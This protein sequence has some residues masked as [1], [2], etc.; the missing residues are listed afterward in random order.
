M[1]ATHF[2]CPDGGR[3]PINDCL[4]KCRLP[5]RC[6]AR[7]AI[8][9]IASKA[10]DRGL[11]QF[12]V[13][14]LLRGTRES[15]LMKLYNYPV[16]PQSLMLSTTGTALHD[17]NEHAVD[18]E[19]WLIT[20]QRYH[21]AIAS[22]QIDTYGYI[23][24][25]N[26]LAICDYKLTTSYKI[27]KALG[28]GTTKVATGEFYKTGL[29]KGQPKYKNEWTDQGVHK[30]MDWAL[31]QN[32]YRILLEEQGYKVDAMYIQ[33]YARDFSQ[34]SQ[35]RSGITHPQY[36]IRLN[37]IS[38]RWLK[39]WFNEKKQRLENA[40]KS[41]TLPPLCTPK[42]TWNGLKCEKYC[43]VAHL[44]R[45]FQQQEEAEKA[46]QPICAYPPCPNTISTGILMPGRKLS[47]GNQYSNPE[48]KSA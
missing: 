4:N 5:Q 47:Y 6:M 29:K 15:Y 27:A 22:G 20:E 36:V 17:F 46:N 31:Q 40:L 3:C 18:G 14:E 44:C 24:N 26:E 32:F 16:D 21:N 19:N 48:P 35:S 45:M 34:S 43:N 13:T 1:P 39:L 28:Y 38:D 30:R 2:I 12:S 23:M 37:K 8:I 11:S 41:N 7:P 33:A 42:E 9:A 25:D 10:G